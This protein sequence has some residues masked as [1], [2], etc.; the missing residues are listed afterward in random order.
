MATGSPFEPV[1]YNGKKHV[2]GQGNNVFIFPGVG[3]GAIL[4]EASEVPE[5]FFM[6]AA[7]TLA[8]CI[9]ADRLE[10]GALYPDQ[11]MLR[12]ISARIAG[13]VIREAKR[14][15]IGRMIPEEQ[16]DRFVRDSMWHPDYVPYECSCP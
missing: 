16:I 14:L 3:L 11:S 7:Q 15:N 4:A 9:T 2:I 1:V 5:S 12:E 6:V 13:N 8:A 10:S